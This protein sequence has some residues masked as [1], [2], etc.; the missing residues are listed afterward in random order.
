MKRVTLIAVLALATIGL[1]GIFATNVYAHPSYPAPCVA[2]GCHE[3]GDPRVTPP[4]TIQTVMPTG[5]VDATCAVTTSDVMSTYSGDALIKLT[6]ADKPGGWGVG[7]IYYTLDGSPVRLVRVPVDWT[8]SMGSMSCE[9]SIPVSAPATGHAAH[10]IRF[11]SQDNY[12]IVEP[13]TT[14]T[15]SVFAEHMITAAADG[16]GT[17]TASKTVTDGEDATFTID[18]SPG[19]HIVSVVVDGVSKGAVS[20][21]AFS[22]VTANHTIAATFAWT[23]LATSTTL[24]ANFKSV[25]HGG[26]VTLTVK[27]SGGTFA[28]GTVINFEVRRQSAATYSLLKTVAVSSS[29]VA[30]YRYRVLATGT[31][32]HRVKFLGNATYLPAPI[33]GGLGLLVR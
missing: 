19:Y 31:R 32:Y 8:T 27:L 3:V 5:T 33:K 4:E 22:N 11:W 1:T 18:A 16:S 7:Y 25:T 24:K 23:R 28:P 21:F 2:S 10:T 29:G 30:S 6:A 17:I 13:A 9:A 14:Q 26:Y 20:S 12:G 15:F